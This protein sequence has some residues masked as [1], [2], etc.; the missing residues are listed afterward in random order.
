M[1]PYVVYTHTDYLDI[2]QIQTYY[3][4]DQSSKVLL[5]NKNTL[6]LDDLYNQYN[7]VIFYDDNLP[8]ASRLLA[9]RELDAEYILFI[10][11]MDAVIRQDLNVLNTLLDLAKASN[12]DRIDLQQDPTPEINPITLRIKL[13]EDL[14]L[15]KQE[16]PNNYNYNVNPSIWKLSTLLDVMNKFSSETYRSIEIGYI[17]FYM[18]QFNV[19]KLF[20]EK[21]LNCGYF[22]CTP[23]FTFLHLTHCGKFLP[24]GSS[25]L[26]PFLREEYDSIHSRFLQDTKRGFN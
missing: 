24:K 12:I 5:I 19:Y 14:T 20:T 23:Y 16:N 3:L 26:E 22:K 8:Y 11:D 13:K 6:E 18:T 2:V 21:Y 7:R 15:I 25:N 9:L 4:K 1:I 17:Q 10:H